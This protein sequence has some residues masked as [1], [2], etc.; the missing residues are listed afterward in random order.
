[1]AALRLTSSSDTPAVRPETVRR[2][3]HLG[4]KVADATLERNR[5][6]VEANRD[7][8]SL[9]D[10]AELVGISY[11]GVDKIIRRVNG[12][13][14]VTVWTT[15]VNFAKQTRYNFAGSV[16][17][18]SRVRLVDLS[19]QTMFTFDNAADE[20]M[21]IDNHTYFTDIGTELHDRYRLEVV[22]IE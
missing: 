11:S 19:D 9:R 4:R 20:A 6:I 1:M 5:A 2:L 13:D 8:L 15:P 18:H 12:A 14:V 22:C 7:G 3:R 16:P 21:P 10:I 17:A